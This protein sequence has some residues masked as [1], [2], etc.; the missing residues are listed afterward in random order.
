ME[1]VRVG[2]SGLKVSRICLGMMTF[3]PRT[4]RAWAVEA[5]EAEP[6]LARALAGGINFF[7]TADAYSLG[8][9]EEITG[10]LLWK[11]AKRDAVVLASKVFFP[12]GAGPNDRG[13]SRKHVISACDDSLRRLRTDYIDLYQIHR[14]DTETPVEETMSALHDLVRA[15]KVRYLGASSMWAW[16]LVKMQH[17]ALSNGWTPFISMQNHYNLIYREEEREMIPC[18]V[19]LGL[20]ILPWSPLARGILTGNRK[21]GGERLTERAKSDGFAD[22]L[23][24]QESDYDVV[25]RVEELARRRELPPARIAL[26]WLLSKPYVTAPIVGATK[27]E[28]LDDA[29]AATQVKLEPAEMTFLEELYKAHPIAGHT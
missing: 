25:A 21:R 23:Y 10:E 29:L 14:F 4:Q 12:M 8:R 16:Q 2:H 26:A 7:D 19:D 18:A 27:L 24:T 9:S 6:F 22:Q 1:Y 5:T 20:G 13:L 15:G 3:G 17:T 11:L 28:H